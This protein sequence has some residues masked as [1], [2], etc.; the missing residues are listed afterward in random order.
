MFK[1][2]ILTDGGWSLSDE[3]VVQGSMCSPI[4]SN[5]FAHY[6][7]DRWFEETVKRHCRG[8]VK[9][10]RYC[11]DGVICCQYK[12]DAER[13][14]RALTNRLAKYKLKINEDKTKLVN[15]SK[16]EY[17]RGIKQG[18]FDFLGFTFYWGRAISGGM[19]PKLKT[20]G[21]RMS[22]KLKKVKQWAMKVKNSYTLKE[23]WNLFCSKLR[24][25]I[26]YYG[27]SH[28]GRRVNRFVKQ[29][30]QI[31]FKWLNRRSQ[32]K[33]FTREKFWLFVKANPLPEVKIYHKFF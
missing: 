16:W 13:I 28:N 26:Q 4:L 27:V 7:I 30:T 25:H 22:A 18:S 17:Q 8:D 31:L 2:G 12:K 10:F 5:I 24:G 32:K 29:A 1:A 6:V 15:Y 33:S 3:G 19:I 21:K 9:L 11:D 14:R 20:S 23:I